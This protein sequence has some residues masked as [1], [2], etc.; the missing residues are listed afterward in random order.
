MATCC[1]CNAKYGVCRNTCSLHG[2]RLILR[3]A[4]RV[5]HDRF[6]LFFGVMFGFAIE[7]SN[8]T[9]CWCP[10][11]W[12]LAFAV[13]ARDCQDGDQQVQAHEACSQDLGK[14][15]EPGI[16]ADFIARFAGYKGGKWY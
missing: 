8:L 4:V 9:F 12:H 1:G 11:L 10:D 7:D 6:C 16:A 5:F 2:L 14:A 15:E 3:V 13:A